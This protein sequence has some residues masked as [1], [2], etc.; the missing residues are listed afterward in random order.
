M[1]KCISKVI[2]SRLQLI[3]PDVIG[4]AQTAFVPGRQ[5]SDAILLTQELMHN[6]HLAGTVSR[7]A[8]KIDIRKAF[9]TVSWEFILLGLRAIGVPNAMVRWIEVC[10]STAHFSVAVNGELHG[11]FQSARGIRQGDPLSPYLFV[12]AMEGLRGVLREAAQD[13]RYHYHWRC[14]QESITHLCFADDLM[15]FCQADMDSVRVVRRALDDFADLSGLVI[16]PEKSHA[17]LSGVDDDLKAS[18]LGLLGFRLGSLPVRYLGVPLITTRLKHSDCLPLVERILSRIRLWTSASLT[19]AGRLQLIKSVLFSIQVYWSTMFI[20]PCSIVRQ[21]EG[22]LA[23]FLWK[24][25]SL[26]PSGAKVAWASVCYPMQE[27]GLGLRG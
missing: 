24:G 19:Y 20:L 12:L 7:C 11:F 6:Y 16:N 3:L 10:V 26:S 9:D 5:I 13:P 25:T 17:F 4:P 21:I 18:L 22:I 8:L 1:Y 23:A 15:I 2:V 14:Q 27:G